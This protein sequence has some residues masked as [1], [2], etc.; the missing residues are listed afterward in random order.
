MKKPL[1]ISLC[2][3][4]IVSFMIIM[5]SESRSKQS[6]YFTD[7]V[8]VLTYHHIDP[9]ES[10]FTISPQ[11][12]A[13]HLQALIDNHY[14]VIPIEEFISFLQ[15][16]NKVPPNAVVITFDDGYKSFYQYAYPELMKRN[17]TA[18]NFLI[19][20]FVGRTYLK[21]SML[22]WDE[23]SKMKKDGFSFYSHTFNSHTSI[24]DQNGNEAFPL[25][26]YLFKQNEH[27][28]EN[29]NEYKQR[30]LEDLTKANTILQDKLGNRLSILCFPHGVYNSTVIQLAKQTGIQYFFT[31]KEGFNS[32][33]AKEIKRINAGS[34]SIT[35]KVL[36]QKLKIPTMFPLKYSQPIIRNGK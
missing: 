19:V 34:P 29:E 2:L 14:H 16:K 17:M 25:T 5:I 15:G 11:R 4:V 30:I 21:P 33:K 24:V 35:A 23:V 13:E 18:T 20:N 31:G 27:R 28:F 32:M 26:S 10:S 7:Y 9:Q 12:F 8:A 3:L 36:I 6:I 1:V 22:N